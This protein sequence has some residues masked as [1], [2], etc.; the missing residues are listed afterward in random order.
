[1]KVPKNLA[2]KLLKGMP[3]DAQS[4]LMFWNEL[5]EMSKEIKALE[6]KIRTEMLTNF[7]KNPKEGTNNQPLR[8]DWKVTCKLTVNRKC[9]EAAFAAVFKQLPKGFKANLIDFKPSLKLA[10][11]K[12]LSDVHRKIFDEAL[13]I[14]NGSASLTVVPPKVK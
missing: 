11:Y 13:I 2:S 10:A 4:R 7:F 8:N 1:M 12:K 9:D 3:T 6:A 5:Q 14:K